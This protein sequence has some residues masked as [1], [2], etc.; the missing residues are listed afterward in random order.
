MAQNSAIQWT[1]ATW[2]AVQP[3]VS[4]RQPI[5]QFRVY[6]SAGSSEPRFQI[7]VSLRAVAANARGNDVARR[8]PSTLRN[9]RHVVPGGRGVRT[10]GALAVEQVHQSFVPD[11]RH[12]RDTALPCVDTLTARLSENRIVGVAGPVLSIPMCSAQ[13]SPTVVD[14]CTTL[15][16]PRKP[17]A[18]HRATLNQS[19]ARRRPLAAAFPAYVFE[20]VGSRAVAREL[21]DRQRLAA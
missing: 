14:P 7:A 11:G 13:A 12:W 9:G 10:V 8:R 15:P 1:E 16:T 18:R 3:A 21:A 19:R 4:Q 17:K 5:D 2:L 6:G 20:A